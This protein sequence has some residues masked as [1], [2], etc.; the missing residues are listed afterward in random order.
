MTETSQ[1]YKIGFNDGYLE[2]RESTSY[3]F[4]NWCVYDSGE[5]KVSVNDY[6]RLKDT[7]SRYTRVLGLGDDTVF[8]LDDSHI[9][10]SYPSDEVEKKLL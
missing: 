1:D 2:G 9:I 3:D 8:V 5:N 6:V 4:S 10:V 7:E